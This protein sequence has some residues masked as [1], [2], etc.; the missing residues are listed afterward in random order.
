[1]VPLHQRRAVKTVYKLLGPEAALKYLL[2]MNDGT[3]HLA[4]NGYDNHGY[5]VLH[6][7]EVRYG[8]CPGNPGQF[9]FQWTVVALELLC[10]IPYAK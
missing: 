5:L 4:S 1:M 8:F 9:P 6:G 10:G 2:K 3:L 7:D